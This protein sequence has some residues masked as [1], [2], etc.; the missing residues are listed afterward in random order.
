MRGRER[1][2]AEPVRRA[3][4][5]PPQAPPPQVQ[6][7]RACG[8]GPGRTNRGE[9]RLGQARGSVMRRRD[10]RTNEHK[11]ERDERRK[12]I[13]RDIGRLR[14]RARP[15]GRGGERRGGD[16]AP[17]VRSTFEGA[18]GPRKREPPASRRG[19]KITSYI[20]RWLDTFSTTLS[21]LTSAQKNHPSVPFF[22]TTPPRRSRAR[23]PRSSCRA[24]P[25]RRAP[26]ASPRARSPREP[27]APPRAAR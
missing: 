20:Y 4:E 17:V 12:D 22:F 8:R 24:R 2:P 1:P 21:S 27:C 13:E 6:A 25:A 7:G 3:D 18:S 10:T 15:A 19:E 23:R 26:P 14:E 16:P 9:R 11:N 5:P